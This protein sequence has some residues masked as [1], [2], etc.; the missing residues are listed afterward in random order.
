MNK[1]ISTIL[2]VIIFALIGILWWNY[3][4]ILNWKIQLSTKIETPSKEMLGLHGDSYG[5]LNAIFSG[6]AMCGAFIAIYIGNRE[7]KARQTEEHLFKHLETVNNIIDGLQLLKGKVS[8]KI[9]GRKRNLYI[10]EG[11]SGRLVFIILR[12]HFKLERIPSHS[13]GNI[14]KYENFYEEYLHR[15]L[16][17]YFRGIYHAVKYIDKSKLSKEQKTFYIHMLRAQI[18]SD[19]LFFLFYSGLSKWGKDKFAP[20]IEKYH[21]FEH[22][23]DEI[24]ST[25]LIRYKKTAYGNNLNLLE[26]YEKQEK[27]QQKSKP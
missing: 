16:G 11:V 21:L 5:S 26:E 18:S 19:E 1:F 20:L 13:K 9:E 6:L 12:N 8:Y 17:H 22:L 4:E 2:L 24:T 15:V 3:P 7:R 27:N 14:G 23:H 10:Q 25:D